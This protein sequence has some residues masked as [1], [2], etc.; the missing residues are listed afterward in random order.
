LLV[1]LGA[2]FVGVGL[3]L[4]GSVRV[5]RSAVIQAQPAAIFPLLND[6]RKFNQWSP[7]AARDPEATYAYTGPDQG[8]GARMTWQSQQHGAGSQEIVTS[9]PS[10]T[11]ATALDLGAM[12]TAK[13][14]YTL[15]AEG[16]ATRVT[17]NLET[18]LPYNPA[19]RWMGLMFD[20]W[21]GADYEAGLARL[22]SLAEKGSV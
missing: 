8:V 22:K 2:V 10:D 4:P 1:I 12:G 3:I 20:R 18:N 14:G 13:A 17:W 5:E 21:I 11:V 7:W 19:A 15:K 9:V 16:G 6:F